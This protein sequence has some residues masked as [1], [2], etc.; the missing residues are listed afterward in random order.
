MEKLSIKDIALAG[1]R[2]L[3]RVD[4]NVP[5]DSEGRV[6]NDTRIKAA[7]PT[8]KYVLD[9]KGIPILMSHLGRPKGK[10]VDNLR[11]NNVA[12]RL[13]ELLKIKV[14]KLD[15]CIG[16]QVKETVFRM[17][18]NE[19]ILLENLR[20]HLEEEKNDLEF[21]KQLAELADVYI[22]DAFGTVHRAHASIAGVTQ[23]LQP[24]VAGFLLQKEIESFEKILKAPEKPFVAILGGAKVSDKI[25]VIENLLNK[26]DSILIGG[27]M[28]YTFLKAKGV[29][30]GNSKLEEDKIELSKMLLDKAGEAGVEIKLPKDHLIVTEIS[31]CTPSKI[32]DN[33]GIPEGWLGVDIGPKT[34]ESFKDTLQNAKTVVW[35]GPLGI[36]EI[37]NFSKGTT[38]IA[39]FISTLQI[40]SIIGG[41][42]TQAAI[43]KLRLEDKMTHVST[44]GGASLEYLEGKTLP[45]IAAL[46]DRNKVNSSQITHSENPHPRPYGRGLLTE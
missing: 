13:E 21:A 1:K 24:T 30:I 44:G 29:K 18:E 14:V 43:V 20:F 34:I 23:F 7:L 36:F 10:I 41:G 16:S 11:M 42:D 32:T 5:L 17:G 37:E 6:S 25:G 33:K 35:N 8:I 39:N 38:E 45:G 22:N 15:E 9:S 12:K 4:F 19:I 46:T 28:S 31:S 2:V 27:G 40:T 26:V 3:I